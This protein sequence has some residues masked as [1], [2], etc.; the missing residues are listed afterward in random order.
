M[1]VLLLL[2]FFSFFFLLILCVCVFVFSSALN[3][4]LAVLNIVYFKF[5]VTV[6]YKIFQYGTVCF[7]TPTDRRDVQIGG[8][9]AASTAGLI[10]SPA[11]NQNTLHNRVYCTRA[12]TV[13]D[14][15][16]A[17]GAV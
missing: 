11:G 4:K 7:L 5:G 16:L 8:A 10:R 12:Q 9:G 1:N 15:V 6:F 2:G 14:I 13:I 17:F 3:L